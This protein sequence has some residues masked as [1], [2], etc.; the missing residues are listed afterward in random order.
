M[1]LIEPLVL[2][3]AVLGAAVG[4]VLGLSTSLLWGV[5]G[6]VAGAL[7]G[8]LLGPFAFILLGL[9]LITVLNGPRHTLGLLRELARPNPPRDSR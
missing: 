7:L 9:V 4:A 3:G 6:L 8:G 1:T 5:G 2:A